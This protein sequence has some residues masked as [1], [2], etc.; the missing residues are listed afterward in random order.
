M[1]C[2]GKGGLISKINEAIANGDSIV[3]P[4]PVK[5]FILKTQQLS[6]ESDYLFDPAIGKLVAL[7]GFHSE[8]WQ[9]PPPQPRII[10]NWLKHR[11]SIADIHFE[12][13]RL[14]SDNANVR[15]DFGGNAKG[16]AL[17]RAI[18][19]LKVAG[20][21]NAIVN[22]GGD[23]RLIGQKHAHPWKIG[24][25]NPFS[26]E[27]PIGYVE[28][29]GDL[30]IVTSGSYQRFFEWKGK[31]YSHVLNPNTGY[32]AENFVSVTVIHSDATTADTA[33]TALMVAGPKN[34]QKI[35]QQMSIEEA[36]MIDQKGHFY[37]TPKMKKR[38][39]PV[40]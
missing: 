24:I 19:T 31:R 4:R 38:L 36:F 27:K 8:N 25:Q 1:A 6:Q 15:L 20:I 35:A 18:N 12:G 11:P 9:G 22:I 37:Q 34:W 30:S 5:Q 39:K 33:A 13:N 40:N 3:I 7:W 23:M 17:D 16:L 21:N 29:E 26:P 28:L 32:P 2:L 14:F 10:Q